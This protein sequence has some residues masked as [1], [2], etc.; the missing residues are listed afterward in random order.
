MTNTPAKY[1]L[2]LNTE[3]GLEK[4]YIT[5]DDRGGEYLLIDA[6]VTIVAPNHGFVSDN[7]DKIG[8]TTQGSDGVGQ[9]PDLN[10]ANA[11]AKT[12][13]EKYRKDGW[14]DLTED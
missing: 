5:V 7:D 8:G 2:T 1:R 12:L 10:S 13:Y 14:Q 6:H 11:A 9:H 3:N 4:R